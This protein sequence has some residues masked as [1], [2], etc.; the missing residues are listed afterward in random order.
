MGLPRKAGRNDKHST[1]RYPDG[2]TVAS[3][4]GVGGN[5]T[6]SDGKVRSCLTVP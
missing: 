5:S 4:L 2:R 1:V 3:P 6:N